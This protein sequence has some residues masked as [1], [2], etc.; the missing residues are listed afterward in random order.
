M[1]T[2]SQIASA[3][4][5]IVYAQLAN[6]ARGDALVEDLIF[7]IDNGTPPGEALARLG[8]SPMAAVKALYRRG[9]HAYARKVHAAKAVA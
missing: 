3:R 4:R 9:H 6:R 1:R 8:W 5:N 7:L 2:E